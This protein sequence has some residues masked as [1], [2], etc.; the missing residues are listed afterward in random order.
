[1]FEEDFIP[2]ILKKAA[3]YKGGDKLSPGN[4]RP[5]SLI[6]TLMKSLEHITR[7]QIVAFLESRNLLNPTQHGIR[8]KRSCL[9]DLLDVYDSIL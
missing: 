3:I 6:T 9:S 4:Y 7:K 2:S 8:A 5:I 1:M